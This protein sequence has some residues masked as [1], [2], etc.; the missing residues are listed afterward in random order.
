MVLLWVT[1]FP[2]EHPVA[3]CPLVISD[4]A[5]WEAGDFQTSF[6]RQGTQPFW[7][8]GRLALAI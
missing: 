3:S 4:F 7:V 2:S 1:L 8:Y 5:V 6:S